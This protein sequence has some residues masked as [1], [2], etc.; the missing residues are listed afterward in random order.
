MIDPLAQFSLWLQ[1]VGFGEFLKAIR[2]FI[3]PR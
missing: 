3:F 1:S 2:P